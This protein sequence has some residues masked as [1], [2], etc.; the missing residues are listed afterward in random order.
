MED[1]LFTNLEGLEI[2]STINQHSYIVII[3]Y[4]VNSIL[5]FEIGSK[6]SC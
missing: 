2:E 4:I 3:D 5:F 1:K 6:K